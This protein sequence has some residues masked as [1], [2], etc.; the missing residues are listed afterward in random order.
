MQEDAFVSDRCNLPFTL[1]VAA[2]ESR[3][4]GSVE[5]FYRRTTF[6]RPLNRSVC[7]LYIS[8]VVSARVKRLAPRSLIQGSMGYGGP[9][10]IR[11]HCQKVEFEDVKGEIHVN[12]LI[13][14]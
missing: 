5:S 3:R 14:V 4:D 13:S 8:R 7:P 2:V 6:A 11:E 12:I 9:N 10:L 1:H